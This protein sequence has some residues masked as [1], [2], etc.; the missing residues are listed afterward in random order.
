MI[1]CTGCETD[2]AGLVT[3]VLATAIADTLSGTAGADA[4]KVKSTITWVG[5]HEAHPVEIRLYDSLFTVDQPGI[6]DQDFRDVINPNSKTVTDG[7]AEPSLSQVQQGAHLQFERHG[8]F[9]TDCVDHTQERPVF[10][11]A[12]ALRQVQRS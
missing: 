10:N 1:T 4:I 3:T 7:F 9:V 5:A 2:A 6:G 8:Y 11:R 12:T